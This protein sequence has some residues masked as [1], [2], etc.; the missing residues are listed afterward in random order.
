MSS[1]FITPAVLNLA[2][3]NTRRGR[4]GAALPST[5]QPPQERIKEEATDFMAKALGAFADIEFQYAAREKQRKETNFLSATGVAQSRFDIE[6]KRELSRWYSSDGED[7]MPPSEYSKELGFGINFTGADLVDEGTGKRKL[8]SDAVKDFH[9]KF[10]EER[11]KKSPSISIEGT[12]QNRLDAGKL[13]AVVGAYQYQDARQGMV[14]ANNLNSI[15]VAYK[16]AIHETKAFNPDVFATHIE[17]LDES[18]QASALLVD[19]GVARTQFRTAIKDMFAVGVTDAM[20]NRD[21]HTPLHIL[22]EGGL[23]DTYEVRK[24]MAGISEKD[25]AYMELARKLTKGSTQFTG[26]FRRGDLRPKDRSQYFPWAYAQLD[27]KEQSDL[28]ARSIKAFETQSNQ[29]RQEL[30]NRVKGIMSAA[31]SP[32]IKDAGFR[33]SLKSSAAKAMR[34]IQRVYPRELF[35]NENADLF[36]GVLVGTEAINIRSVFDEIPTPLMPSVIASETDRISKRI[37][38]SLPKSEWYRALPIVS[39]VQKALSDFSN[40]EAEVRNK[41]P[42]GAIKQGSKEVRAL[43]LRLAINDYPEGFHGKARDQSVLRN[44]VLERA[45]RL[46]MRPSFLT[47]TDAATLATMYTNGNR[48]AF[49]SALDT[50]RD[51]YGDVTFYDYIVPEIARMSKGDITTAYSMVPDQ[52]ISNIILNASLNASNNKKLAKDLDINISSIGPEFREEGKQGWLEWIFGVDTELER[53]DNYVDDTL[54]GS[55]AIEA[56]TA[57]RK[58][59]SDMALQNMVVGRLDAEDAVQE[60]FTMLV[61]GIGF[62][63]RFGGKNVVVRPQVGLNG[64]RLELL[65]EVLYNQN[66]LNEMVFPK[67][68]P[69]I[70]VMEQAKHY[71]DDPNAILRNYF[72]DEDII[73]WKFGYEGIY[74]VLQ[75]PLFPDLTTAIPD[76]SGRPFII[77]YPELN[78]LI[79]K[80]GYTD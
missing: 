29:I 69:N 36:T 77:P 38:A 33:E 70:Y 6:L 53:L 21:N 79:V 40:R 23:L 45:G 20:L 54:T 27:L 18:V 10:S 26:K 37:Q 58:A 24:A 55:E 44:R 62:P 49:T 34:D 50:V 60:A 1:P 73:D 68:A 47:G 76:K 5:Y 63:E 32:S 41:D 65:S 80:Q 48:G 72:G 61:S 19:S 78:S 42:Y 52:N 16:S 35:P 12:V 8:F 30:N 43:D 57:F 9:N 4:P 11:V 67:I 46:G 66:F 59:V 64:P 75:N 39:K 28:Q 74:P 22:S 7:K 71:N 31:S 25:T 3:S 14:L 17:A 15:V 13:R 56:K 2:R 51:K